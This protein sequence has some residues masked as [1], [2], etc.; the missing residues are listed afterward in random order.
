[1]AERTRRVGLLKAVGA[2]PG[3]VTAT[4]VAENLVLALA[5]AALGLVIGWLAAPLL[6]SPGAA[7][8]G[9]PGAPSLTAPIAG[10]VLAVALAV[11]L[12]A[13]LVPAIRAARGSTV[14]ALADAPRPPRRRSRLLAMSR[15]LPVPLLIGL[16][17]IAR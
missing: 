8:V 9:T 10:L 3:L 13:T 15:R 17:L 16:R 11:A 4:L 6:T 14:G 5:A 2:S 7:L 1:M 12:G